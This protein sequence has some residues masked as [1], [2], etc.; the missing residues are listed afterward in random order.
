[1]MTPKRRPAAEVHDSGQCD[2]DPYFE[3]GVI[4]MAA[5]LYLKYG[6]PQNRTSLVLLVKKHLPYLNWEKTE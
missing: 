2:D 4:S 1:M 6:A 3:L 5:Y